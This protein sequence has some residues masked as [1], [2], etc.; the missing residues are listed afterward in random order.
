MLHQLPF[1]T[2]TM[3]TAQRRLMATMA[4]ATRACGARGWR[5]RRACARSQSAP[6]S[7]VIA[8]G[9]IMCPSRWLVMIV[10]GITAALSR[11]CTL[12]WATSKAALCRR[13][14]R[15]SAGAGQCGRGQNERLGGISPQLYEASARRPGD[16]ATASPTSLARSMRFISKGTHDIASPLLRLAR[17]AAA[18][19]LGAPLLAT[20]VW[21]TI[22]R[23]TRAATWTIYVGHPRMP[24]TALKPQT[25]GLPLTRSSLAFDRNL[26]DFFSS[27]VRAPP[28]PLQLAARVASGSSRPRI[29]LLT[30]CVGKAMGCGLVQWCQ[31]AQRLQ[32]VLRPL[33]WSADIL[34]I[35]SDDASDAEDASSANVTGKAGEQH[36]SATEDCPGA[37]SLR[38]PTDLTTALDGCRERWRTERASIIAGLASHH[39]DQRQTLLRHIRPSQ[40]RRNFYKWAPFKLTEYDALL[41]ADVDIDL[42]PHEQSTQQIAA[43]WRS[44]LPQ[45]LARDSNVHVVGTPDD[46]APLNNGMLLVRPS[47]ALYDDGLAVLQTCHFNDSHGWDRIGRPQELS[48]EQRHLDGTLAYQPGNTELF[49]WKNK[50]FYRRNDWSFTDAKAGQGFFFYML[51]VRHRVCRSARYL[52]DPRHMAMHWMGG[53]SKAWEVPKGGL[54]NA[55]IRTLATMRDYLSRTSV[56]NAIGPRST[57]CLRRLWALQRRIEQH[58]RYQASYASTGGFT[59]NPIMPVF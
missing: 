23:G 15:G 30:V 9:A 34:I 41:V 21:P 4:T 42:L 26:A 52:Q 38:V 25:L 37:I 45:L 48:L 16:A 51:C 53:G 35:T 14:S 40:L 19:A 7:A 1:Q 43:A 2:L 22:A 55:P 18:A 47:R 32:S 54:R 44:G 29:G 56:I 24:H 27:Q 33:G 5:V 10:V 31:G 17:H 49:S 13:G 20:L 36:A 57:P 39:V 11:N 12:T 46:L 28:P 50:K 58:P 8:V 59:P 6:T 3:G